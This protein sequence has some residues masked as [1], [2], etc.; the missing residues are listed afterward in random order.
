[1]LFSSRQKTFVTQICVVFFAYQRIY[2][3]KT[4]H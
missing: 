4:P 1:M 2:A 3:I